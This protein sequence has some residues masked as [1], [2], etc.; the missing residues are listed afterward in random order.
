MTKDALVQYICNSQGEMRGVLFADVDIE[1]PDNIIVGYS[2]ARRSDIPEPYVV[3]GIRM[4]GFNRVKGLEIAQNR[5]LLWRDS[6]KLNLYNT[7]IRILDE[8]DMTHSV[9]PVPIS[10]I[11]IRPLAK[12]ILRAIRF[13]SDKNFPKWV[14]VFTSIFEK[15][16]DRA[17]IEFEFGRIYHNGAV[18]LKDLFLKN[19]VNLDPERVYGAYLN[20]TEMGAKFKKVEMETINAII[21]DIKLQ[22]EVPS[23]SDQVVIEQEEN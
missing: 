18:A 20:L 16:I 6:R 2:L 9:A 8:E 15:E 12:F 4:G 17:D 21:K 13:Y 1:N 19:A 14:D 22:F 5:S 11:V 23:E 3:E 10:S 7:E